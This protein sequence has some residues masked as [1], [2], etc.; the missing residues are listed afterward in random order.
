MERRAVAR[1]CRAR[2][3]RVARAV[4][5][6]SP[7]M[8]IMTPFGSAIGGESPIRLSQGQYGNRRGVPR[9]RGLLQDQAV[10]ATFFYP[11]VSAFLYSD[12]VRAVA[13]DR[14]DREIAGSCPSMWRCLVRDACRYR[15]LVPGPVIARAGG[16]R[17][18]NA[19]PA[20][21]APGSRHWGII[22]GRYALCADCH[23]TGRRGTS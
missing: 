9:I 1:H 2:P 17:A 10:P 19:S 4:P 21:R 23:W 18:V 8:R 16:R 20:T 14:H 13:A 3:G 11:A 6:R 15:P 7:L 12:E 22:D 5:L